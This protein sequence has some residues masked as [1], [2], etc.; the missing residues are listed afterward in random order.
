MTISIDDVK[1]KSIVCK[2]ATFCIDEEQVGSDHRK[3]PE[4]RLS[5]LISKE[6][7]LF[8][9][10]GNNIDAKED[11][12]TNAVKVIEN[13]LDNITNKQSIQSVGAFID[14]GSLSVGYLARCNEKLNIKESLK[15]KTEWF[16]IIYEDKGVT[17]HED[18]IKK[19]EK[20]SI[21]LKLV[22]KESNIE[23]KIEAELIKRTSLI[24]HNTVVRVVSGVSD[25]MSKSDC[26]LLVKALQT[27]KSE[28]L[29]EIETLFNF[30]PKYFTFKEFQS[31][32]E[33]FLGRPIDASAFRRKVANKI[34]ETEEREY[35]G[36]R[37]AKLCV[38]KIN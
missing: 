14:E 33:L 2:V 28:A 30:L 15:N 5:V 27:L 24:T 37:K 6:G 32:Y 26:E 17:L 36:S 25:F 12:D 23:F 11:M 38:R 7:D 10:I 34:E 31:V 8:R 13:R 20:Q 3:L 22:N 29:M 18:E 4:K 35:S 1:N 16:N 9:V 21:E 19:E